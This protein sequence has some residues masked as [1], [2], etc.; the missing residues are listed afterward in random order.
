MADVAKVIDRYSTDIHPHLF[1]ME[2]NEIFFFASHGVMDT[3]RHKSILKRNN[4]IM[5]WWNDD[6]MKTDPY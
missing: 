1:S 2:G 5:E 3:N 6:V 4:G